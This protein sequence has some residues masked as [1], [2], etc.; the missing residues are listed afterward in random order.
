MKCE[1]RFKWESYIKGW[2][3]CDLCGFFRQ[4]VLSAVTGM[5][6][7]RDSENEW[8]HRAWVAAGKVRKENS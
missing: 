7:R 5:V 1:H 4:V 8:F 3:R 2:Q 6:V